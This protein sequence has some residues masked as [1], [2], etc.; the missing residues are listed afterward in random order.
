MVTARRAPRQTPDART[1]P[2]GEWERLLRERSYLR[3]L[4][5]PLS[6]HQMARRRSDLADE[7]EQAEGVQQ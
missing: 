3:P 1:L 2:S 5:P 6:L 4:P 7:N